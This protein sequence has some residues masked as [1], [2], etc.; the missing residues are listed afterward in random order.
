MLGYT[1][2]IPKSTNF[3]PG[4]NGVFNTTDSQ[5]TLIEQPKLLLGEKYRTAHYMNRT[6]SCNRNYT[7]QRWLYNKQHMYELD[8]RFSKV[9]QKRGKDLRKI[10]R[11][12]DKENL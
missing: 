9:D 5:P 7:N 8:T 6:R 2:E 11:R 12:E 4:T 10:T 3:L 1:T